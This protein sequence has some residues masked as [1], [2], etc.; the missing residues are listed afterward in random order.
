MVGSTRLLVTTAFML[1]IW[2]GGPVTDIGQRMEGS[3]ETTRLMTPS[4]TL[5]WRWLDAAPMPFPRAGHFAASTG[6]GRVLVVGGADLREERA[7]YRNSVTT[8]LFDVATNTWL[9]GPD[10]PIPTPGLLPS[11]GQIFV[12][13]DDGR[14]IF[15]TKW[16]VPDSTWDVRPAVLFEYAETEW[17][18]ISLS[19]EAQAIFDGPIDPFLSIL[20]SGHLL[21][22]GGTVRT[23]LG[24]PFPTHVTV[25]TVLQYD[26]GRR[27]WMTKAPIGQLRSNAVGAALHDGRLLVTGG[28]HSEVAEGFPDPRRYWRVLISTEL[29]DP[30][31]DT[32]S[33][34]TDLA[35]DHRDG[36]AITLSD[37]R[38]LVVGGSESRWAELYD[39]ELTTWTTVGALTSDRGWVRLANGPGGT[40]L[41]SHVDAWIDVF[42][43][44]SGTWS[45][46]E[47][48]IG[49]TH[50]LTITQIADDAFLVTG[51]GDVTA[52][53]LQATQT[54]RFA[55]LPYSVQSDR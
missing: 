34:S 43:P 10:L 52:A 18:P 36:S 26:F 38:I 22:V 31:E 49:M 46:I 12:A 54:N 48:P 33:P 21:S 8:D 14:L 3:V 41:I 53:I 17:T 37:G 40:V 5:A 50:V 51:R 13:S 1:A 20:D 11:S 2:N 45:K 23:K 30:I 44:D 35:F 16:V 39:P 4:S 29:Y 27:E 6:D 32:W 25:D 7:G 42:H 47:L 55:Y 19:P 24:S 9:K 15:L 28:L